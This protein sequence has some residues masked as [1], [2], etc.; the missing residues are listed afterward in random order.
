MDTAQENKT[1]KIAQKKKTKEEVMGGAAANQ[2]RVSNFKPPC[3]PHSRGWLTHLFQT[4]CNTLRDDPN[5]PNV[6]M[7]MMMMMMMMDDG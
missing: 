1:T 6:L 5:D 4:F 3:W 7:M 2:W